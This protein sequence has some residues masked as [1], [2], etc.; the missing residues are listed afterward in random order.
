MSKRTKGII[1]RVLGFYIT[2]QDLMEFF[3]MGYGFD[4]TNHYGHEQAVLD[5]C[6]NLIAYRDGLDIVFA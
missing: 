3:G 2:P 6:G 5:R 1:E 4:K